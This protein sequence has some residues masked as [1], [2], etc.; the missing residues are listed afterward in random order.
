MFVALIMSLALSY[1]LARVM[2]GHRLKEIEANWADYRCG[3]EVMIVANMFKPKTDPRSGAEFAYDNFNFCTS[4]FAKSVLTTALKPVLEVFYQMANSAIQSIGFTMNLR[5]LA[6]NLY[7]GLNRIFDVFTRRFNL[8]IHELHRTFV[9]Q[10][11]ALAKANAIANASI[12]AGISVIRTIMNM[13]KLMM[14]VTIA[15]L[16]IL[17]VLVIFLFFILAPVIPIII[18]AISVLSATAM[19]GAVGGMGDT[20]CFDS[21]T[22]IRM[23]DG[24]IKRIDQV[25]LG[26]SLADGSHVTACMR[27]A[28]TQA[29]RFYELD[30]VKVAGSHIVYID[31]KPVMVESLAS[32]KPVVAPPEV[33]CLNTSRHIIPVLGTSGQLNFADWE[34][35][36][37]ADMDEWEQLVQ[38]ILN[39]LPDVIVST[40]SILDAESGFAPSVQLAMSDRSRKSICD[41]RVGD[42][43]EDGQASFTR[44]LATVVL[45]GSDSMGLLNDTACSSACWIKNGDR[46]IRAANSADWQAALPVKT[47]YTLIT[48]SGTFSIGGNVFRDFTEVGMDKIDQTYRFT[49]DHITRLSNG[50]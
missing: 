35:L 7:A 12:Y 17:I 40:R 38:T 37:N 21:A 15:I 26:D 13:F 16:V 3:P 24:A 2:I 41:I 10:M 46:W 47:M 19:A 5:T 39:G 8:T 20:F 28:T 43:V 18:V 36:D 27:F 42:L 50:N 29:T 11:S 45:I 30:G 25:V 4:E 48:E 23:A 6:S 14:I 33:Y 9:L 31:G 49:L 44:V 22:R 34:E 32:A 1:G